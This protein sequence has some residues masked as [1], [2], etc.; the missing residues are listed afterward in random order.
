MMENLDVSLEPHLLDTLKPVLPILDSLLRD[1]VGEFINE[2][3]AR[4]TIPYG[5]LLDISK[6]ARSNPAT[7][8]ASS[9][10]PNDY[11]MI[12]L[13]AGTTTSP[14][15][16]F[17]TYVPPKSEEVLAEERK[18]ER[19]AITTIV[20]GVFSVGGA[21]AAAWIGSASTGWKHEWRVLFSFFIAVVVAISE[22]VLFIIWSSRSS[23]EERTEERK[24]IR[25]KKV[26]DAPLEETEPEKDV[27]KG[28]RQRTRT[29]L[30]DS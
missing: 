30:P 14:H 11:T 18:R 3:D 9:L 29:A 13:L 4:T 28:L 21:G 10:N 25:S 2:H 12:A 6:W 22:I 23:L 7:L 16:K 20:N 19:K 27:T 17:G 24:Y 5:L 1:R 15:G 26:E 8:R